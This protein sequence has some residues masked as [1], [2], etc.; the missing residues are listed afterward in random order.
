VAGGAFLLVGGQQRNG[1]AISL[2]LSGVADAT[3]GN[4]GKKKFEFGISKDLFHGERIV[5]RVYGIKV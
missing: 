1:S 5:A 4:Q 3:S 2:G